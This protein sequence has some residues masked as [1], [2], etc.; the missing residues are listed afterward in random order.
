MTRKVRVECPNC[1][2]KI[3]VLCDTVGIQR[4]FVHCPPHKNGCDNTFAL[5]FRTKIKWKTAEIG[6]YGKWNG[7][8]PYAH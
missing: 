3:D 5:V 6:K 2:N 8:G 1:G 7:D 4:E